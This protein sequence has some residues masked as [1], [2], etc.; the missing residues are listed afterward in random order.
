MQ[1]HPWAAVSI[2]A[3]ALSLVP[4]WA[5]ATEVVVTNLVTDDMAAHPALI[6]DPALKNAWGLSSSATSPFWVSNNG[7][8]TSTLYSVN[9]ATQAT[10]KS[11]LTVAIPGDGSVTGQIFNPGAGFNA[12]RFLFVSE[13]G[14]ISGW[15]GALGSSAEVLQLSSPDNIY[16]GVALGILG[17][18]SYLYAA[19]FRG[20]TIDVLKGNAAA[21]ALSGSFLDP[22]LPAGFAPF[23][24]Q[25]LGGTLYVTYAMQDAAKTDEVAG[26]GLGF[27]DKFDLNGNFL[28]RV[29]SGG[30][31]DAPWGLAIAPTAFGSLAGA[32]LVGN[33]GD[34][35]ISA[36][37][38]ATG[39]LLGQL[40]DDSGS[41]L[42]IDGL[43]ALAIGNDGSGG[44]HNDVY[45]TAGPDGETHGLFGVLSAVASTQVPEPSGIVLVLTAGMAMLLAR[46]AGSRRTGLRA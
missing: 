4:R 9:P 29:A 21:P 26:L 35:R 33:F 31:L 36:F 18:N 12:D 1:T 11:A 32:L 24:I 41:V 19:D 23:N 27:V 15:R 25:N 38:V 8:G 5:E 44:S 2:L 6:V 42:E 14:T 17:A 46:R 37:D 34:G 22:N 45:F 3:L 43:W 7:T 20:G 40:L 30:T 10:T 28:G 13:D 39:M 16:K